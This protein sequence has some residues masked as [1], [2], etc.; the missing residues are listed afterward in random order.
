[1]TAPE[2]P[3]WVAPAAA[4]GPELEAARAAARA[5]VGAALAGE[6]EE[7]H[8]E[9][10]GAQRDGGAAEMAVQAC[11]GL[12]LDRI[13]ARLG[14]PRPAPAALPAD[15]RERDPVAGAM[16]ARLLRAPD[17]RA[18]YVFLEDLLAHLAG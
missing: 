6:V 1:M 7:R 8:G 18:R 14:A 9:A 3:S 11:L 12:A 2:R 10:L 15:L 4:L 16:L 5:A 13:Y 17:T